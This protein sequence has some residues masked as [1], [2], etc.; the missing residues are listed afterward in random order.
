MF[1]RERLE[2]GVDDHGLLVPQRAVAHNPRGEPTVTIVDA[3]NK[4]VPRIIKTD[5]AIG[6]QWLVSAGLA[7]GEKIIMLGI[8]GVQPGATV[9]PH[10]VTP[11][12]LN[13]PPPATAAP[14]KQ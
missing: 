11:Q 5:R 4:A 14:Q 13:P 7:P 10:E 1:V 2:E 9:H 6:D 12:E 8:Q 3:E